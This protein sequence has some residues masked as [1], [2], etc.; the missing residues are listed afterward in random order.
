MVL[1]NYSPFTLIPRDDDH[2]AQFTLFRINEMWNQF[3]LIIIITA[4]LCTVQFIT[5][6]IE[7]TSDSFKS[8]LNITFVL[9]FTL[10]MFAVSRRWKRIFVYL[11]PL[12]LLVIYSSMIVTTMTREP[13]G[14]EW[15]FEKH[16]QLTTEVVLI[17]LTLLIY[18]MMFSPSLLFTVCVYFPIYIGCT[19]IQMSMRYDMTNGT[20]LKFN[21]AQVVTFALEGTVFFYLSQMRELSRFFQQQT[22][23][24]KEQQMM[25]VLN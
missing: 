22:L 23:N 6:C 4:V 21:I 24:R 11:L 5:L 3:N 18:T 9:A 13:I 19:L 16:S 7:R 15:T 2:K 14:D 25:H 8:F 17:Q 20:V 12:Q 1:T 10:V